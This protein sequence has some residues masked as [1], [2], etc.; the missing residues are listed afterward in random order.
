MLRLWR[1]RRGLA[2]IEFALMLPLLI[3]LLFGVMD[4]SAGI[5]T[6]RRLTIAADAVATIASTMAVQASNLN[7]LL[8]TQAWQAT[9]AP[10]A[11]FPQWKAMAGPGSFAITLSSVNFTATPPGCTTACGYT[12]KT[13]WSA[14][15]PSGQ[16]KLRPCGT[17]SSVPDSSP[18]TLASL[19]A[20]AFAATSILVGDVSAVYVPIFTGVFVGNVAMLRSAYVSPRVNNGVQLAAGFPGTAVIC[21]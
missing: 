13:A 17:L 4:L 12:A 10:F 14:A 3:S 7:V 6:S 20:D 19:P 1:G 5:I 18:S 2:G 8:G 21:P 9:T 15:N 11:I 16:T